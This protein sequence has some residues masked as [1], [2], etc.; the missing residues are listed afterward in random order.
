MSTQTPSPAQT[1][2]G[3]TLS[4]G[5]VTGASGTET[6][7]PV[8]QLQNFKH[9]GLKIGTADSSTLASRNKRKLGTTVDYGQISGTVLRVS[10]DPGQTAM[11][12][13]GAT[14]QAYDFE[15]QLEPNT[16]A[17]QT[18]TGDLITFSGIITEVGGFD[19]D[20]TKPMDFPFTIEI[21][22]AWVVTE[23]H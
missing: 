15:V 21:D 12:A 18:T 6:F 20:L 13:A 10:N 9:S 4:I 16:E 14:A 19:V 17:G 23:G 8:G 2:V 22:G 11:M 3:A 7:T 1:G 5:G